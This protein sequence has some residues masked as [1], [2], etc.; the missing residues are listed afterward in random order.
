MRFMPRLFVTAALLF[1]AGCS[2]PTAMTP[3]VS[4]A[5][6]E[7][8][9]RNQ[10]QLAHGTVKLNYDDISYGKR[11][12]IA[13]QKHLQNVVDKMAPEAANMCREL[14]GPE[15]NCNMY[16]ELS[17]DGEGINAYADGTKIVIFPTMVDFAKNETHLALVVAHEYTHHFMRHVQ[18]SQG[19]VL[20]GALLGTLADALAASQGVG[21]Q[22]QF[23]NMGAQAALLSYSPSFEHE[24]DYIALYI[25]ARAGFPI[26]EAPEFWRQMARYNPEGIYNRTTHPTTPERF[27]SLEKTVREIRTKQKNG[28]RL[29]P[30]LKPKS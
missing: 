4:A 24:A 25:L 1:V 21:T 5:E 30:N 16:V 10:Q 26:E 6:I 9:R 15:G 18:S 29:L 20:A 12:K 27:A 7:A 19:N 2:Q 23:G 28:E 13:M 3:Q 11:E 8:E 14:Q 22:G 17:D